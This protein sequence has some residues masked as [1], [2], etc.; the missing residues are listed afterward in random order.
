MQDLF[1]RGDLAVEVCFFLGICYR[2]VLIGRYVK[3]VRQSVK[4]I[5]WQNISY[6]SCLATIV[7]QWSVL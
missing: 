5:H 4:S 1:E 7:V 2:D 3:S 6:L